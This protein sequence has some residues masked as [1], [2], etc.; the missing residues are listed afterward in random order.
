MSVTPGVG[1]EIFSDEFPKQQLIK[2]IKQQY[3][4]IE[5]PVL[6]NHDDVTK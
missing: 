6:P 3:R 2:Q 4:R 5:W 1:Q